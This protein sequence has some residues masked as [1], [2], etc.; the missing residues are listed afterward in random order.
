MPENQANYYPPDGI[1]GRSDVDIINPSEVHTLDEMFRERVRRSA[2]KIAYSEF[3]EKFN[4]WLNYS[5]ADI[6]TQVERWQIALQRSALK[7]G[8]RVAIR[9]KNGIDWVVCDQASLRLGLVVVPLYCDDRAD[10][11]NYVL[12]NS[13]AK[14]LFLDTEAEWEEIRDADGED[15]KK[16]TSIKNVI[17][18]S[19]MGGGSVG[20]NVDSSVDKKVSF[21]QEWLP[22]VGDHLER[23]MA[24]PDDLASIVYTSGTTGKPKGVM[25][26]HK[27]MLHNAYA[28]MRS[29]QLLPN[30]VM[31]SFLPLSHTFERTIGYYAGMLSGVHTYYNR[32]IPDLVE[33]LSIAKP[34]VMIAVPRIFERVNNKIYQ[35]VAESSKLKKFL[36]HAAIDAGWYRFEYEQGRAGWHPKLIVQ[37]ILDILVG[38]KVRARLGGNLRFAVVGGAP[39]SSSV[40][41]TFIGLGVLLLQGYGLTESSPVVSVNTLDK[42][43]PDSIGLPLRGVDIAIGENDELLVHGDNVMQGYWKNVKATRSV[44]GEDGWLHTGDQASI[45]DQGFIRIIGRLKDI[46][47]LANGE[48]LP[49]ADME[50]AILKDN[51]FEQV[52]VVGEGKAFLSAL[53][54]LNPDAWKELQN[55]HGFSNKDINNEKLKQICLEKITRRIE[56]FPGYAKI[57]K[58]VLFDQEWSVEEGLI[59]P[60]LKVKRA[61]VLDKFASQ[62]EEIYQGHGISK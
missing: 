37:P 31:L 11:V 55:K 50:A 26:S 6:A 61:R 17:V 54:V 20:T 45:D 10:N 23:G 25:L 28:G 42:N 21:I 60:T 16:L 19:E 24:E 2:N 12:S 30:D 40:A 9:L 4:D 62:V 29:V 53:V 15:T 57:H 56:K 48:K 18:R 5:W 33:D 35:G 46:L 59:T 43:K 49:P 44:L 32:S 27:N 14:L 36:F 52:M 22:D 1:T 47:V 34:S 41:E 8:D 13:G 3:D 38:K 51:L 58:V 39:L 7:K